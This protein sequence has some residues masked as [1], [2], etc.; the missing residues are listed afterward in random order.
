VNRKP[1]SNTP[2]ASDPDLLADY[3]QMAGHKTREGEALEWSESLIGD[4]HND[5]R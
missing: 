1:P 2:R 3:R 5:S 4:V